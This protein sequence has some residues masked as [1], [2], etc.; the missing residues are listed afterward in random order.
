MKALLLILLASSTANL[1]AEYPFEGPGK[2]QK[3]TEAHPA[4][5]IKNLTPP[6]IESKIG[7]IAFRPDGTMVVSTWEYTGSVYFITGYE[8]GNP[9]DLKISLFADGLLE[10]LGIAT[11][12]ERIFIAQKHELTELIDHDG[13]GIADEHRCV[14]DAW[15]VSSN[16]HLF[17]FGPAYY[18]GKLY[19][20][21]AISI[22]P[23]G[24]T[25]IGQP[26]DRGTTIAVDP[27]TGTYEVIAAG[28]RTPNGLHIND[29]GDIFVADNQGDYLPANK[30]MHIKQGRF[31]ENKYEPP[32]P[33]SE[34][35]SSP[36]LVWLPQ[37]EIGNSPTQPVTL[38]PSWGA[39]AGQL[40]HG[41]IHYG[42]LQRTFI[43]E[44]DGELQG[45]VFRFSGGL[46]GGTNRLAFDSEDRLYVGISGNHGNW[47]IDERQGIQ[48]I[49]FDP[50]KAPFEM[51]AIRAMNNGLEIEFTHP[52][53][54]GHGWDPDAYRLDTWS[55][56]P[57]SKYGGPKIDETALKATSASVSED[58]RR[59]F[60][61]IPGLPPGNVVRTVLHSALHSESGQPAHAAEAFYTLNRIPTDRP[62]TITPPP[63]NFV[64]I[65][66]I[67]EPDLPRHIVTYNT[68]CISCHSTDGSPLVGPSFKGLPGKTQKVT[69]KDGTTATITVDRDY[70]LRGITDTTAEYPEGF[71]PIMPE[72]LHQAIDPKDIQ[73][74][75]DWITTL[76]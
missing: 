14:S 32:H 34:Q 55:Y 13:N 28:L 43:D 40:V 48:Q 51:L 1:F 21:L 54:Q 44:V 22:N 49:T 4:A 18:D 64:T 71:Q 31:Y 30:I 60:L 25:T 66:A 23:G 35:K 19:L 8:S 6:G 11:V 7:G 29:K 73:S 47:G 12:G 16:F 69:R 62:G 53:A 76:K 45:A 10:P 67:T 74:V 70:I 2:G 57:T 46:L 63:A 41:D 33:L 24:A 56:K 20:N 36:P 26:K 3:L 38:P 52:L 65:D 15:P 72:T 5:I 37:N 42:G 68:Y 9:A 50:T 59:V 39:Y 58:R 75:V 61:E 17:T 27:E